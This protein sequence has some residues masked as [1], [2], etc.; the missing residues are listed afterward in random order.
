MS[1]VVGGALEASRCALSVG[2]ADAQ[3]QGGNYCK[4]HDLHWNSPSI[5]AGLM[6][7]LLIFVSE[8]VHTVREGAMV[9]EWSP[10]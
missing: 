8:M 5:V 10:L 6:V 1:A 7:E 3:A 4:D 9:G 2:R